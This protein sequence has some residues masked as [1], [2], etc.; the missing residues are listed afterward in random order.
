[1]AY[2]GLEVDMISLGNADSILVTQWGYPSG[3]CR[4]LIDGGKSGDA[5]KVLAFLAQHKVSYLDHIICSHPH[6]DHAGGLV[7]LIKSKEISFGEIWMH[8]PWRHIDELKLNVYLGLGANSAK[9]IVS[10]VN[11]S[12]ETTREIES[13]AKAKGKIVYEPFQGKKIG[14]LHV[15]GPRQE[16][17]EQLLMDFTD[18]E[19]LSKMEESMKQ[20]QNRVLLEDIYENSPQ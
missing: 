15:L 14:F 13:A 9:K 1:M 2:D 7:D 5:D 11:K 16:F 8:L 18:L 10:I 12:L 3:A 19:K 6:E 17:Y 4:V 20:Y